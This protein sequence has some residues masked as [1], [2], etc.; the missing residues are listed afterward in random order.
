ME[1]RHVGYCFVP[2]ALHLAVR[3]N[4]GF[5]SCSDSHHSTAGCFKLLFRI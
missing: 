5:F 3:R 4:C 2:Q 1:G